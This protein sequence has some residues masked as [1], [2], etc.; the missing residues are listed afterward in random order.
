MNLYSCLLSICESAKIR[1][2]GDSKFSKACY[3]LN[4]KFISQLENLIIR[5]CPW[6]KCSLSANNDAVTKVCVSLTTFPA[7]INQVAYSIKSL[8]LQSRKPDRITLWL[9]ENQFPTHTIPKQLELLVDKGLKI[10]YCD[11]LKSHKKYYYALQ[12]QKP[13]ELVITV[14]DDIIY[15]PHTIERLLEAH[16]SN[17]DAIVCSLTHIVTFDQQNNIKPYA[18]WNTSCNDAPENPCN[19]PLTGSGCLYPYGVMG[20]DTFNIDKIKELAPTVDDI[21]I[22]VMSKLSDVRII[23]PRIVA[24]TF[25]VVTS[26][27]KVHLGAINCIRNGNDVAIEKI[28]ENYPTFLEKLKR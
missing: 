7:R 1:T 16:N 19:M 15:H 18:E 5:L 2:P 24:K 10:R 23:T 21:W 28:V 6:K 20:S 9:A 27:Q 14:D 12:E 8:M 17:P 13:D 25:T 22:G 11:D 4:Y 26:S 3:L